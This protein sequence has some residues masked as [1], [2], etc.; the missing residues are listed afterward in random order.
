M[1]QC[2][3]G[4]VQDLGGEGKKTTNWP[5]GECRRGG[6]GEL[7]FQ[8]V[9]ETR[10]GK[11][12]GTVLGRTMKGEESGGLELSPTDMNGLTVGS[13]GKNNERK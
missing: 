6:G 1:C 2:G 4:G 8:K 3:V 9:Y 12:L 10:E 11:R 7:V 13:R 5:L